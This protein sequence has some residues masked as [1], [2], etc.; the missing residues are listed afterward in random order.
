[1]GA[2]DSIWFDCPNCGRKVWAQSKTGPCA[3]GEYHIDSVPID[4]AQDAN[5]HAPLVCRCGAKWIITDIPETTERVSLRVAP[6]S[7]DRC[8]GA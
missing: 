1:M 5:R 3:L 8:S 6:A 7:E 4:V 2:F